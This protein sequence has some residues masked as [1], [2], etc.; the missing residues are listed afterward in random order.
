VNA[1]NRTGNATEN[2]ANRTADATQN[3]GNN[4]EN[5]VKDAAKDTTAALVVT[6]KVSGALKA[7]KIVSSPG[8]VI[9]VDSKDNVVH[10]KGTVHTNDIKERAGKIAQRVLTEN[11]ST[12][13]LSNEL[14]VMKH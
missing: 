11:H 9:N 1:A 2:A 6:P 7:D 3:A 10:L 14:M 13:K 12:D 8:N 5:A 4:T